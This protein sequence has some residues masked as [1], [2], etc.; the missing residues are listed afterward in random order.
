M[1]LFFGHFSL[2]MFLFVLKILCSNGSKCGYTIL[3]STSRKDP[4]LHD[5]G[6]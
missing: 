1:F 6:A 5:Q 2:K 3:Y 4:D